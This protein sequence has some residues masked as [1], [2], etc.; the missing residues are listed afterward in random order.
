[1]LKISK[2]ADYAVVT[3]AALAADESAMMTSGKLSAKTGLPEPTVAKVLKLLSRDN[4]IESI[5]GVNGGYKMILATPD[6]S[7]AR[8]IAAVDGP[9]ALT[10]CVE[11][12]NNQPCSYESCCA[13]KG[14]WNAVNKAVQKTLSEITLADMT[15]RHEIGD[16]A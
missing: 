4:I 2:M 3:L 6:I 9:V 11:G 16:A 1:M 13:V 8:I 7:L 10:S 15:G 5:R 14:R 12:N